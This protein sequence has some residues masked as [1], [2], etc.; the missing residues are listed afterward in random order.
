VVAVILLNAGFAFAQEMQAEKAVEAL[1]AFLPATAVVLRDGVRWNVPARDLVP[2]DILVVAEGDRVSA[3]AK[4]IDGDVLMDL[5]ALT[6]ES[7]PVNR[8][9]EPTEVGGS[10][11]GANDLIFSGTTCTGGEAT[12]IATRTAM[13]TELGRIAALSQRGTPERSPLERQ[14]R[15]ATVIIAIVAVVAGTA[16]LPLGLVAGLSF[17]AAIGLLVA[18]VPEGLLPTITL[19]LSVGVR[20]LARKGAVVKR[21]SAVETLGSTTVI[22]TDKTGT[23]TENRMRVTRLWLLGDEFDATAPI[24]DTRA[25][26]L[27]ANAAACTTAD[28]P[29]RERT[30][31][32]GDPTERATSPRLPA[33]DHDHVRRHRRLPGRDRVCRAHRP[34]VIVD[35]RN[36]VQPAPPLGHRLRTP[37]HRRRHIHAVPPGHLR[38]G[39]AQ[40]RP[41]RHH[42]A[43]PDRRVGRR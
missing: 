22:C 21:L 39:L 4:I 24:D 34:G 12:A 26:L 36:P 40:R 16:F 9:A 3:D 5:S 29:T 13:H 18:N 41:A 14:V 23:L 15:R 42:R 20:E 6:G 31:G 19:A 17:S 38:H 11:I 7:A 32:T 25:R 33:S 10:L 1:A 37:V 43:V 2:G 28:S 27:C 35:H 30:T 8:S